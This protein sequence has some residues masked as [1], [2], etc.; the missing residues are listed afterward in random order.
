M[1]NRRYPPLFTAVIAAQMV[2]AAAL[3][4]NGIGGRPFTRDEAVTADVTRRS[5][6]GIL[7]VLAN[8][9]ANT[10]LYYLL[11]HVWQTSGTSEAWL[12]VPSALLVIATV[13]LVAV[14]AYRLLG[15]EVAAI[16]GFLFAANPFV[17]LHADLARTYALSLFF[18]SLFPRS[19][20]SPSCETGPPHCSS[21]TWPRRCWRCLPTRSPALPSW[22]SSR[23][24]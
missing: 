1:S 14:L 3:A 16:S 19:S 11:L 4:F 23:R 12:R 13:P 21:H 18:S 24:S 20:S 6:G 8:H 9:D 5:V 10:G 2:L 15:F 7:D 17:I 22:R